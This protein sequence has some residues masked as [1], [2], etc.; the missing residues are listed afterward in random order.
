MGGLGE[1]VGA[2]EVGVDGHV[3]LYD[4][5]LFLKV[6]VVSINGADLFIEHEMGSPEFIVD[7][8]RAD[9]QFVDF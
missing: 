2:A 4:L 3:H 6:V 7:I 8:L 5:D 9:F 1:E